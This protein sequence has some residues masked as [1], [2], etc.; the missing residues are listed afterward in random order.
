MNA[1]DVNVPGALLLIVAVAAMALARWEQA[2]L[3]RATRALDRLVDAVVEAH[4]AITIV[5]CSTKASDEEKATLLRDFVTRHRLTLSERA[6]ED[7]SI[8]AHVHYEGG[9]PWWL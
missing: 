3:D 2:K 9:R 7:G 6:A 4:A 1:A 8:D 5:A